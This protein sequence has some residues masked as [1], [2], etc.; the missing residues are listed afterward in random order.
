M[1]GG[2]SSS[3]RDAEGQPISEP[4]LISVIVPAYN[5]ADTIVAVLE[6]VLTA[7]IG[8]N[9]LEVVVVDDGSTDDTWQKIETVTDPRLRALRHDR[10]RGKGAAIRTALSEVKGEIV[11]IQDADL[12]YNPRDYPKLLE[13]ILQGKAD[14]VYGSRFVG[15]DPHRVLYFWHYLGN[16]LVTLLSNAFTNLNLTDMETGFKVFRT[17]VLRQLDLRENRF[18]F[19]PEVTAKV[20]RLGCRI[21]EV[22]VSYWGRRYE[23]GKKVRW[24]DGLRALYVILKYGLAGIMQRLLWRTRG[25]AG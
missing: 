2:S 4:T 20:A 5:E 1:A 3:L 17:E 18:G 6:A 16:K 22:G 11:I 24:T 10:N 15:H 25:S 21:Y 13:P 12:E 7:P 14:V 23:E 8:R 9:R 19:E